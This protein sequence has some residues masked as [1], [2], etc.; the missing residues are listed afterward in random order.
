M[1]FNTLRACDHRATPLAKAANDTVRISPSAD[2][3]SLDR[4]AAQP[5]ATPRALQQ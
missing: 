1:G 4:P 2:V 3:C 5:A